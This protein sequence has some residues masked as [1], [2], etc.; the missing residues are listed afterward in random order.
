MLLRFFLFCF[1]ITQ[2]FAEDHVPNIRFT[3][4][5][6]P[7]ATV[8]GCV[9]VISGDFFLVETDLVVDG[10][11]PL[12]FTRIYDSGHLKNFKFGYGVGCQIPLKVLKDE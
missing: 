4:E 8:A 3:A 1:L 2:L 7:L 11:Q 12:H 9:N 5:A 10:I 6:E